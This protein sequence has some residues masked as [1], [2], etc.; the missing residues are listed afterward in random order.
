[1]RTTSCVLASGRITRNGTIISSFWCVYSMIQGACT[2]VTS[3]HSNKFFLPPPIVP[4]IV[5]VNVT[6]TSSTSVTLHWVVEQSMQHQLPILYYNLS[7]SLANIDQSS[8]SI[9]LSSN[10]SLCRVIGLTPD[11]EYTI[12]LSAHNRLGTGLKHMRTVTTSKGQTL[13]TC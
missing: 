10:A 6:S 7:Y 4:E 9:A 3:L 12:S 11:K 8:D 1:M 2:Y 5:S 13:C